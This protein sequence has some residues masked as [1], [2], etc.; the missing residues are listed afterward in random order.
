MVEFELNEQ[1][2][3]LHTDGRALQQRTSA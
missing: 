1:G 2:I 3:T